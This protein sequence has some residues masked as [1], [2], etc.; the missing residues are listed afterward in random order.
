MAETGLKVSQKVAIVKAFVD[1]AADEL[2]GQLNEDKMTELKAFKSSK[3]DME[4]V[5][6]ASQSFVRY[7]QGLIRGG[8][9]CD[10]TQA[11]GELQLRAEEL[12]KSGNKISYTPAV[13]GVRP[14]DIFE[15]L[16]A[17]STEN[18]TGFVFLLIFNTA[19]FSYYVVY[20][21]QQ[22]RRRLLGHSELI[23]LG[24]WVMSHFCSPQPD[25]SLRWTFPHSG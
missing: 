13:L 8:N 21:Q 6:A 16:Y 14:S 24:G 7:G 2:N 19:H 23:G 9:P 17:F 22:P 3:S 20:V 4:F 25:T 15:K 12:L 1:K 10:I 18:S 5:I 11:Y